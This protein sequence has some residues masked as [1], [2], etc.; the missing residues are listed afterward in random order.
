MS[1]YTARVRTR[2]QLLTEQCP[3]YPSKQ[4]SR[5]RRRMSALCASL[6]HLVGAGEQRRRHLEAERLGGGQVNDEIELGRL[7]DR[8]VGR[9]RPT[10]N[11]IDKIRRAPERFRQVWS[12]GH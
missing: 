12:V 11:L 2:H 4:T 8:D 9:P 1:F 6:D 5:V 7:L 10:K 3:L